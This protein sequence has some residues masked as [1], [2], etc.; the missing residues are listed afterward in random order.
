MRVPLHPPG[1]SG[2]QTSGCH[3]LPPTGPLLLCMVAPCTW[4][5]LGFELVF[6]GQVLNV[7]IGVSPAPC[8]GYLG[9]IS[10]PVLVHA[11]CSPCEPTRGFQV[12]SAQF[13]VAS[14]LGSPQR[15]FPPTLWVGRLPLGAQPPSAVP[16]PLIPVLSHPSLSRTP[17][18]FVGPC[19]GDI[20][21][22]PA[23]AP[24][25]HQPLPA[26]LFPT[27]PKPFLTERWNFWELFGGFGYFSPCF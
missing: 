16:S 17:Q 10:C 25:K 14:L 15:L 19:G 24:Q 13:W 18:F 8:A 1:S 22:L 27:L 23:P 11:H 21:T 2:G 7:K 12:P 5:V 20:A 26:L 4:D 9:M 3:H 6:G